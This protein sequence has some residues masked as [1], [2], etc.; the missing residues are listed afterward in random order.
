MTGASDRRHDGG[1]EIEMKRLT[2]L[3]T[4]VLLLGAEPVRFDHKVRDLY[5]A[6]FAG[7]RKALERA[8][9][10]TEAALQEN[11]DHA[12]AL[13]WHGSGVF[14]LSADKFRTG[15]MQAGMEL[16]QKGTGMMDRAVALAPKNIGVRIP[17][18]SAYFGASRN[19]P[20]QMGQPLVEKALSDFEDA[21][22]M[23]K[24]DLSQ[25][26]QHS[27]GELWIGI[28]DG[29]ARLGKTERAAEFFRMIQ[30]KLPKTPWAEKAERGLA[31]GKLSARDGQC[32]GCHL[33]SPKAFQN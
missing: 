18:G 31:A 25:F 5:F 21:W 26:S 3:M 6:A 19:M 8:M 28:A 7:D 15:D 27:I 30:E 2:I 1:K 24:R 16:M 10:I 22:E 20:P 29:N 4:G 32:V 23:Q 12:E 33:G 11:P 14:F 17:R 13:V 9:Q